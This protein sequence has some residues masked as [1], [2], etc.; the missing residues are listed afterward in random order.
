MKYTRANLTNEVLF[1]LK[2]SAIL[3]K[4]NA[5]SL[6]DAIDRW[7]RQRDE[8]ALAEILAALNEKT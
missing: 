8:N 7:L 6:N 3:Q 4:Q 1:A 2:E 5:Q